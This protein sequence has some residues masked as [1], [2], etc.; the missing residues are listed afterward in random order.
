MVA[1]KKTARL[2]SYLV[3]SLLL[4]G[5]GALWKDWLVPSVATI[6]LLLS[7]ALTYHQNEA[8]AESEPGSRQRTVYLRAKWC[9]VASAL[10]GSLSVLL[11]TLTAARDQEQA[12]MRLVSELAAQQE[13]QIVG[14]FA[15]D[16]EEVSVEAPASIPNNWLS[17]KTRYDTPDF[18]PEFEGILTRVGVPV[19]TSS[20]GSWG[21]YDFRETSYDISFGGRMYVSC[22]YKLKSDSGTREG[23]SVEPLEGEFF[24]EKPYITNVYNSNLLSAVDLAGSR[25]KLVWRTKAYPEGTTMKLRLRVF[26]RR[27][28]NC[29]LKRA[30]SFTNSFE[31]VVPP[32]S[33]IK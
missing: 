33:T 16:V 14:P 32:F 8:G 5:I 30:S 2:A 13:R 22:T 12:R 10:V 6:G 4:I 23:R 28:V 18:G 17:Y 25:V 3:V 11:T 21:S 26:G 24:R 29:V 7:A 20:G 19:D 9:I 27:P 1:M 15:F 31:G